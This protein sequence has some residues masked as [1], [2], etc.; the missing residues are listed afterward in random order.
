M[1]LS[2]VPLGQNFWGYVAVTLAAAVTLCFAVVSMLPKTARTVDTDFYM[3]TAAMLPVLLLALMVRIGR[4]SQ[5]LLRMR[6]RLGRAGEVED[7]LA[8]LKTSIEIA[9]A[10]ATEVDDEKTVRACE[11]L[12]RRVNA[13]IEDPDFNHRSLTKVSTRATEVMFAALLMGL[14]VSSAGMCAAL[15]PLATGDSTWQTLALTA[16][17]L[18]WLLYSL[19][20]VEIVS[21][22]N[23]LVADFLGI[24]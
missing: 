24:D 12:L 7:E 16:L 2:F 20:A 15:V 22:Q 21:F 11:D 8:D 4:I 6:R 1:G 9:L 5:G 17:G 3:A 19:A 10:E 18:L 23:V 14:I 13:M